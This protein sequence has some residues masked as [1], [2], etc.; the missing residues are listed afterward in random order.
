M[1]TV[2]NI[3][4]FLLTVFF[5][6]SCSSDD[7]QKDNLQG[8]AYPDD[9]T[10]FFQNLKY[11]ESSSQVLDMVFP[12]EPRKITKPVN[13]FLFIHGGGWESGDKSVYSEALVDNSNNGYLLTAAMNYRMFGENATCADMLDDIHSALQL[14]KKT[15][16]DR[17]VT[18][19][20]V[21]LM[22]ASAGGHLS[23]LYSYENNQIS[24]IPIAFCVSQAGPADFTDTE[25]YTDNTLR[26]YML[27]CVSKLL[28]EMITPENYTQ[29]TNVLLSISPIH[30]V[31]ENSP[32]TLIAHGMR[33]E[34]V[35][36]SNAIRLY[37][38][39]TK[40]GANGDLFIYPESAHD[41]TNDPEVNEAFYSKF[42]EYFYLYME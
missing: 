37:D 27:G 28:G 32:P 25:L 6:M 11:G 5:V 26:D 36:V 24:P 12:D 34:I 42:L 16:A 19:S 18:V 22:G 13:V 21:I 38:K 17:N 41:L 31:K 20:K 35:P 1:K 14:I 9:S 7:P 10:R 15:A 2:K 3:F 40:I 30:Y 29:K 23:M 39:I 4:Y 33:D 8:N